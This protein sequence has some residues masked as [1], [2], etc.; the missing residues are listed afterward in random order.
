MTE[1]GLSVPPESFDDEEDQP[2]PVNDSGYNFQI[3]GE[4]SG[5]SKDGSPQINYTIRAVGYEDGYMPIW[6]RVTW[7]NPADDPTKAKNKRMMMKRFFYLIGK[8]D[9]VKAAGGEVPSLLDHTFHGMI[10]QREWP[11]G[12]GNYQTDLVLPRLPKG[13]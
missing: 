8:W 9:E 1:L 7:P 3:V 11:Q 10:A 6:N 12:S 4:K 5:N 2:L 13:V